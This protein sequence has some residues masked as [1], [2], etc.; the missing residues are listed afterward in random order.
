MNPS[1]KR[2]V[3]MAPVVWTINKKNR[4]KAAMAFIESENLPPEK[5]STGGKGHIGGNH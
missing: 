1:K 5:I 3:L 4:T 2:R